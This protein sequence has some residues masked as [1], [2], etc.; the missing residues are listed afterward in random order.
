MKANEYKNKIAVYGEDEYARREAVYATYK[1]A[2]DAG[3]K[4]VYF[5][6]GETFFKDCDDREMCFI[7]TIHPNDYGFH[8]MAQKVEPLIK[9]LLEKN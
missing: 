2:V 9:K 8:L 7:D 1:N 3:D 4:N 5:I 6:D